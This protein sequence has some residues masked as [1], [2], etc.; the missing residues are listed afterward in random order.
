MTQF[1]YNWFNGFSAAV[2]FNANVVGDDHIITL[3]S[4]DYVRW[5]EYH[6]IQCSFYW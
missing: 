1:G 2:C 5:L 6:Y 3:V 4:V